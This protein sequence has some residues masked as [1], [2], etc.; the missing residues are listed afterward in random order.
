MHYALHCNTLCATLQ[1]TMHYITKHCNA[2]CTTLQY[3]MHYTAIYY[4]Q[5]C[6]TLCTTLQYTMHYIAIHHALHCSTLYMHYITQHCNAL[7]YTEHFT[8][9][10]LP[11]WLYRMPFDT[12]IMPITIA[13]TMMSTI[14]ILN[15][16]RTPPN[17]PPTS[18]TSSF[19]AKQ[20]ENLLH[21]THCNTSFIYCM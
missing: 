4:A 19:V 15:T 2:L 17:R 6:N 1:Y 20:I 16:P 11:T 14:P 21:V 5:H 13:T 9:Y 8:Y 3:T 12:Y 18:F 7:H 10:L